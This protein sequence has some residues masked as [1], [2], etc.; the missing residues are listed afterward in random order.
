[1]MSPNPHPN[2]HLTLLTWRTP[3]WFLWGTPGWFLWGPSWAPLWHH[4]YGS[5]GW[6]GDRAPWRGC[7]PCLTRIT[8]EWAQAMWALG[9]VLIL[10]DL[11][12][13][14]K[15]VES[16]LTK[17]DSARTSQIQHDIIHQVWRFI[18]PMT[19]HIFNETKPHHPSRTTSS[20]SALQE[21]SSGISAEI[22]RKLVK[23]WASILGL[24]PN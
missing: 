18:H 14:I 10:Q 17:T 1:M 24:S 7:W 15:D 8:R 9:F 5:S 4:S 21:V 19:A 13:R 6:H 12:R 16:T 11:I 22:H 3:H 20:S 2:P 23:I